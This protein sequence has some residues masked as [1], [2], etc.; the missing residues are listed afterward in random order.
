MFERRTLKKLEARRREVFSAIRGERL[1]FEVMVQRARVAGDAS[2]DTLLT[3]V[4]RR[5]SEIEER[6]NQETDLEE[7]GNLI[8]DAEQQGQLSAYICPAREIQDEG[9]LVIDLMEEWSVPKTVI[10]RLRASLGQKLK[11][12]D[13]D[14]N[15]A[16][17]ALRALFEERDSWSSYT[18][19][20]ERKMKVY[21]YWLFGAT[22][23]LTLMALVALHFP[24]LTSLVGLL[25]AGAAGSCVSVMAKMPVLDVSLSGELEAYK[26]RI[27][28][29]I[30]VGFTASLIGCALFGWGVLPVSIQNQSFTD[31]F[32]ACTAAQP[33]S[34]TGLKTLILLGV[35]MLFGF[36]ERALTSFEQK[37]FGNP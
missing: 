22:I 34:C 27:F 2:D 25:C 24:L 29:R 9:N 16:R 37:L 17:S 4:L 7:L 8:D 36:S 23:L 11:E 15:S 32:N 12:S 30:G 31:I 18:D 3:D 14:L 19:D 6:A 10:A 20:Y 5:L 13:K 33:I 28:A 26:R 1:Q 35:P 21:T